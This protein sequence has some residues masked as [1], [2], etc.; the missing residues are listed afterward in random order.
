[1]KFAMVNGERREPAPGLTGNCTG[2]DS[3]TISKCGNIKVHHWAHKSKLECD[4]WWEN[5]TEWHRAWK[6]Q[7]PESWQEIVQR[8]DSGELHRADVKTDK[9]WVL[10]FQYSAINPEERTSRNDFYGNLVWIVNGLRRK[11]DPIQFFHSLKLIKTI[12]D[13]VFKKSY[14][15]ISDK[16]ALLRDWSN[17]KSPV[18]FDFNVPEII[19]CLLPRSAEGKVIIAEISR[20][21]FIEL[22][23][24]N[25]N[26]PNDIF[27]E[28]FQF[29]ATATSAE[30]LFLKFHYKR[31]EE[32][33]HRQLMAEEARRRNPYINRRAQFRF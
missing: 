12:E 29:A 5:E 13:K 7:F 24:S 4:P 16:N 6:K 28:L 9:N 25:S 20:Q 26:A 8:A 33:R 1:M 14:E 11:R 2:C 21:A 17:D 22:H 27:G 15:V 32:E 3:P 18:F 31:R 30:D 23:L 19:W 10:E